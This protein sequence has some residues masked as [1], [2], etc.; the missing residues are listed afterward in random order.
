MTQVHTPRAKPLAA[1]RVF[2][3]A[4]VTAALASS[5]GVVGAAQQLEAIALGNYSSAGLNSAFDSRSYVTGNRTPAG[6]ETRGFLAFD[7]RSLG[8]VEVTSAVLRVENT[9]SIDADLSVYGLPFTDPSNFGRL[10]TPARYE[11][12]FQFIGSRSTPLFAQARLPDSSKPSFIELTLNDA[13]LKSLNENLDD[14]YYV[15]GMRV[16]LA[17]AQTPKPLQFAFGA[18][19]ALPTGQRAQLIVSVAAA[20]PE[21]AS[22]WLLL[23][24]LILVA[25]ASR[26]REMRSRQ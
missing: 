2:A 11:A 15:F 1:R 3:R 20:V 4:L 14:D 5:T 8:K 12:N 21:V 18:G 22:A 16:R 10:D 9:L 23:P 7:L 25:Y 19:S 26:R 24:G 17:D 13:A 6:N